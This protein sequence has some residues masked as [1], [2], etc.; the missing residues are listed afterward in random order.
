MVKKLKNK[1]TI[2]SPCLNALDFLKNTVW[3]VLS[4]R[5]VSD[6]QVELEYI[7]CDGGSDDDY[8]AGFF[9]SEIGKP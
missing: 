3:S 4:Q 6:D 9:D 7:I 1:I 8:M 2:N 5:A